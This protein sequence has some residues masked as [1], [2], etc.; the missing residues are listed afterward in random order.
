MMMFTSILHYFRYELNTSIE[1]PHEEGV[2]E[3]LFQPS[4]T[5]SLKCVS[6]GKDKKFKIWQ[7][8]NA[9]TIYCKYLLF[10]IIVL[11]DY[12]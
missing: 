1:F 10:L 7:L 4:H 5:D 2:S 8:Q 9:D 11:T 12:C 3:L 6:V